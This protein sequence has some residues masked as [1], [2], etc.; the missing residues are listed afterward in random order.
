LPNLNLFIASLL[1]A[2]SCLHAADDALGGAGEV[3]P[4]DAAKMEQAGRLVAI[5]LQAMQDSNDDSTRLIDAALNFTEA[6]KIYQELGDTE[7]QRDMNANIFWCKK[8]MNLDDLNGFLAKKGGDKAVADSIAQM[9]R[10]VAKEIP[11]D[12]AGDYY[13]RAEKFAAD[14]KDKYLLIAIRYFEVAERF[15]GTDV[16]LKAQRQSLDAYQ[17]YT[18]QT[19]VE[20]KTRRQSTL[21]V[22]SKPAAEQSP[23]PSASDQKTALAAIKKLY[24]DDYA[25]TK[26]N[27]KK[28]CAWK[29]FNDSKSSEGDPVTRYVMLGE[30]VRLA[31][32]L[33]DVRGVMT[34]I[35]ESAK[36]YSGY[37]PI[38][39]KKS[40]LA[41]IKGSEAA[42]AVLK[43]LD[44]PED[45]D[46]NFRPGN[47]SACRPTT[48]TTA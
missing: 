26:E 18:K 42:A 6:M 17:A 2:M 37:D 36:Y 5:G 8:R 20:A 28:A 44:N 7:K 30:A 29:L 15:Q 19:A 32:S 25:G 27:Q 13:V 12:Q 31:Q 23:V 39:E 41:K 11:K 43:L 33:G 4:V 45:G 24:K 35:D 22:K 34:F 10:I 38:A 47:I 48:G 46:A 1:V 9:D 40:V 3:A 16:S 21:F 14:N